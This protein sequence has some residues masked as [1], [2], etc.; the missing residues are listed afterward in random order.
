MRTWQHVCIPV[1][2]TQLRAQPCDNLTHGAGRPWLPTLEAE[3]AIQGI[4]RRDAKCM[5]ARG[6]RTAAN[7]VCTVC[8]L[9]AGSVSVSIVSAVSVVSAESAVSAISAV[10]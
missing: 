3:L 9:S 7:F 2:H 1:R 10:N 8:T 4:A 6:R 5:P